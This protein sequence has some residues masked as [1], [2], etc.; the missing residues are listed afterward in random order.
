MSQ[1]VDDLAQRAEDPHSPEVLIQEMSDACVDLADGLEGLELRLSGKSQLI[2]S[3]DEISTRIHKRL[4][5][6]RY[7]ACFNW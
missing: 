7:I 4:K 1:Y 5:R 2:A 3:S 6:A